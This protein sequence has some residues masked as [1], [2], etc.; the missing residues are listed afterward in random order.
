MFSSL[1][2]TVEF[3]FFNQNNTHHYFIIS[4]RRI[5]CFPVLILINSHSICLAKKEMKMEMDKIRMRI[6]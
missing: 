4:R 1:H 6:R 5:F 2:A 3:A